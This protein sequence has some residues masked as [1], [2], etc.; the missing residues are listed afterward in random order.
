MSFGRGIKSGVA[1]ILALGGLAAAAPVQAASEASVEAT[2]YAT[3]S[4][5]SVASGTLTFA[6]D[7]TGDYRA[8]IGAQ[9]SGF[10]ALVANRSASAS[11]SGRA[12]SGN[13]LARDYALSISGGPVTNAVNMTF[14]GGS[15]ASVSAT[16]LRIPGADQRIPVTAAHKR[17]VVDPLG[18]FVVAMPN[19]RDV[20]TPKV[21]NRT[22]KVFD[23][24]VR[25]D[26]R[27]VYGAKTAVRGTPGSYTG[28]AIVCAVAYRPIAGFRP[29]SAEQAK[30]ERNIEFSIWFVPVGATN[31]LIPYKVVVGTPMGLLT[32]TAA[33]FEVK[34]SRSAEAGAA[35]TQAAYKPAE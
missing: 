26:L 5:F 7:G 21:C 9:V 10:A 31:V 16:E 19:G 20:M 22:L 25:Y 33:R 6:L 1:G 15:V 35:T 14:S 32:V 13:T 27:L 12:R 28:P 24:R 29:L 18:A 11:A 34:G 3:L 23:G 17:G 4:G 2:Y 30:F 8:A